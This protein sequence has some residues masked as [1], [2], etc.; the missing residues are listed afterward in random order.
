MVEFLMLVDEDDNEI[1]TMEKI[2]AR[3]DALLH[4]AFSGFVVRAASDR[5]DI[6]V[7]GKSF[8][9]MTKANELSAKNNL[10]KKAQFYSHF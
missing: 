5:T 8:L 1:G 2:E 3:K 7:I 10:Y 9:G 4:R 6:K